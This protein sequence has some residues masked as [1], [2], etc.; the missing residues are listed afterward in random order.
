M[1]SAAAVNIRARIRKIHWNKRGSKPTTAM[2]VSFIDNRYIYR[3]S[4][5]V[6]RYPPS[7]SNRSIQSR[8]PLAFSA[9]SDAEM[10]DGPDTP[11]QPGDRLSP[12]RK[13]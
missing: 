13:A 9:E 8:L 6:K 1:T 2:D 4:I 11:L 12:G 7:H 3:I 10:A 5:K